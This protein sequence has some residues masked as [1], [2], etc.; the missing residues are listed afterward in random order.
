MSCYPST[1]TAE[2]IAEAEKAYHSLVLGKAVVELTDQNGEKV[3]FAQAKR[4]DL[5]QYI[6]QLK[7]QLCAGSATPLPSAPAGFIF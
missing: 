3:R 4:S 5:Y 1:V 6:Q 7:A 2:M